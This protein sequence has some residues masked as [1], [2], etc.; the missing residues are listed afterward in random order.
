MAGIYDTWVHPSTGSIQNTFSMLTCTANPLMAEIHNTKKRM[1]V[2][3]SKD[4]E[5]NWL[6]GNLNSEILELPF[7]DKFI[8]AHQ[9][10]KKIINNKQANV[11]EVLLPFEN[12]V[13]EQGSLF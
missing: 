4:Q 11:P 12:Q 10:S 8:S 1:P 5:E 6:Q 2:I 13:F 9:I 7:P 3:L